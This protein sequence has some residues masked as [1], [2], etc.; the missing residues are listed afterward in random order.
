MEPGSTELTPGTLGGVKVGVVSVGP[1]PNLTVVRFDNA[2]ANW[3][4][5]A[6]VPEERMQL[7][8]FD[9]SPIATPSLPDAQRDG[10]NDCTYTASCAAP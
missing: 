4:P 3:V 8:D 2:R 5:A 6:F 1:M 10:F 7:V 9:L